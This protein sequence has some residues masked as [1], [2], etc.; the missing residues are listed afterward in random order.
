MK[1]ERAQKMLKS[2]TER[3]HLHKGI[4]LM[5]EYTYIWKSK[6]AVRYDKYM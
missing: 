6:A 3:L 1:Q 2:E 5:A 4:L